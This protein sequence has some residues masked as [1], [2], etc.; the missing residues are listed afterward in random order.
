[1]RAG[2]GLLT[3]LAPPDVAG[4]RTETAV[5]VLPAQT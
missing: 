4:G 2:H 5:S 1:M 3:C